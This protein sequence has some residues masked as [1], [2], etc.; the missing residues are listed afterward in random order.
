[1]IVRRSRIL[2]QISAGEFHQSTPWQHIVNSC[3]DFDRDIPLLVVYSTLAE[4]S[5]GGHS[6]SL[7]L[8]GA[9]GIERGHPAIPD[10]L[11]LNN[12]RDGFV[13][14]LRLARAKEAS[15]LLNM[16]DGRAPSYLAKD[17]HWRGFGEPSKQI[18]VVPLFVSGLLTGFLV[19]GLNPR[20]PYDEDH[21][22]FVEDI[23]RVSQGLL[24]SSISF[25]QARAREEKLTKELTAR[26][27]LARSVAE[28]ATVGIYTHDVN[29]LITWANSRFWTITGLPDK[30]EFAY[31]LAG[32][33]CVLE[34]DQAQATQEFAYCISRRVAQ[35]YQLR[36]K[37]TWRPP[38]SS[39]DEPCWILVS[40]TPTIENN[41]IRGILGCIT[42]ISHLK[43]AEQLQINTAE[44]AKEAKRQQER[45]IDITSHEMRNPLSAILQCAD[46]ISM[47][48]QRGT[49]QHEK[50][51]NLGE[52]FDGI[53]ENARTILFCAAHQK[54][55]IDDILTVSKLDSSMLAVTPVCV[56]ASVV[57]TQALQMFEIELLATE[58][59]SRFMVEQSYIDH[60]VKNVYC[61]P[62]R[63]TQIMINLLTNAIKFT[64]TAERRKI[65]IRLGASTT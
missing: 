63:L 21:K 65:N 31:N 51:E 59:E 56:D 22:Q 57:V 29:G 47:A 18:V 33:D 1:M 7:H 23:R 50:D 46:S 55:I 35:P 3:E 54:R 42:D 53:L 8:E 38:G 34:D 4:D 32:I 14:A 61:D 19:L 28:V 26:E 20:R 30:P 44:A 10:F 62:S 58:I 12:G 25:D 16:G 2:H 49:Q 9:L 43:W 27:K 39:V 41:E 64:K 5:I 17:V 45:F 36:L 48:S 37:K 13:S 15:V 60:D 11:E 52:T 6:C 40:S 24:S